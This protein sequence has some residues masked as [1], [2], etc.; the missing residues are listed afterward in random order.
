MANRS[1]GY[2]HN[3]MEILEIPR[4]LQRDTLLGIC[5]LGPATRCV[6]SELL[7]VRM[8]LNEVEV[9]KKLKRLCPY[10]LKS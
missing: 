6:S 9:K 8:L 7:L 3:A 5:S 4:A 2:Y 10:A 1:R